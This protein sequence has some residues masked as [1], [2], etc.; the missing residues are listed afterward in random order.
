MAFSDY[1]ISFTDT[2]KTNIIIP[3]KTSDVS[4]S[5]RL[6]GKG[7]EDYGEVFQENILHILENFS[8]S[9]PPSNP[10]SGQLWFDSVNKR[11]NV[12]F[13]GGWQKLSQ[14]IFVSVSAPSGPLAGDLWFDTV[15]NRLNTWTGLQW[16]TSPS[17][18]AF[19]A[20]VA[21]VNAHIS[22]KDRQLKV[23]MVQIRIQKSVDLVFANHH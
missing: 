5:I 7:F 10:L 8:Y 1:L 11:L 3:T 17:L 20:H 14:Q 16:A 21:D 23:L 22:T 9:V 12:F 4:T 18:Q 2:S 13:S 19:D 15:N 6:F